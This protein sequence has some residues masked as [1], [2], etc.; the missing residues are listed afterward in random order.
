MN[1]QLPSQK[2]FA[3]GAGGII[4][5][6]IGYALKTWAGI[7]I[8]DQGNAALATLLAI[9]LAHVVPPSDQDVLNRVNDTIAQAGTIVGKLTPASD[10]GAPVTPAAQA[11]ADT[12]TK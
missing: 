3:A 1:L 2:A 10:S 4:G 5:W 12:V 11:L 8:G 9:I 7:D 6:A